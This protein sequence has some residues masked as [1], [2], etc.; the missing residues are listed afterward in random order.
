MCIYFSREGKIS[1]EI[2]IN[3]DDFIDLIAKIFF[4]YLRLL[5]FGHSYWHLQF[6]KKEKGD[7]S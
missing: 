3:E 6:Y 4:F 1:A 5:P 2:Q 7:K